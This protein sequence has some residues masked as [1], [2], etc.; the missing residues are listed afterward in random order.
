MLPP[1]DTTALGVVSPVSVIVTEAALPTTATVTH[2]FALVGSVKTRSVVVAAIC[3]E[4]GPATVLPPGANAP[5]F[6]AAAADPARPRVRRVVPRRARA[7]MGRLRWRL[8]DQTGAPID[9]SALPHEEQQRDVS[10]APTRSLRRMDWRFATWDRLLLV[11][12]RGDE[13]ARGAEVRAG[14]DHVGLNPADVHLEVADRDRSHV[15]RATVGVEARRRAELPL[16]VVDAV[17]VVAGVL[18]VHLRHENGRR[19]VLRHLARVELDAGNQ[20]EH[21]RSERVEDDELRIVDL[22]RRAKHREREDLALGDVA[23]HRAA[24]GEVLKVLRR[25]RRPRDR[26][27]VALVRLHEGPPRE[28]DC[29]HVVGGGVR[30]PGQ[31]RDEQAEAQQEM[32]MD[33]HVLEN[34]PCPRPGRVLFGI[35]ESR[36]SDA[37][38]AS[39]Q[40]AGALTV[41]GRPGPSARGS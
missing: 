40:A 36:L 39:M 25:E 29:D 10:D 37:Q 8:M 21:L 4:A 15:R 18:E 34:L 3:R 32:A 41:A 33:V 6:P 35:P 16:A 31:P 23:A 19:G 13:L 14:D 20:L 11:V 27:L 12:D 38:E 26:G 1:S 28:V 9:R 2:T 17:H 22:T 24:H 7:F 5:A 30:R